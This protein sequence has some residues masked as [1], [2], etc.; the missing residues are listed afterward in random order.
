MKNRNIVAKIHKDKSEKVP[1]G[2]FYFLK[3]IFK[4]ECIILIVFFVIGIVSKLIP[5]KSKFVMKYNIE[6]YF[7]DDVQNENY[8]YTDVI[9]AIESNPHISSEDKNFISN[10]L[11]KEIEENI[12]YIDLETLIKKLETLKISY[13][14]KY[15]YNKK[16]GKYEL[17]NPKINSMNIMGN[18]NIA[19]NRIDLYEELDE[20]NI[21]KNYEKEVFDVVKANKGVYFH[22][23][24]HVMTKKSLSTKMNSLSQ[25]VNTQKIDGRSKFSINFADSIRIIHKNTFSEMINELFTRE[26]FD[27]YLQ[28]NNEG[29]IYKSYEEYMIY[30]YALAEILPEETLREYKFNDNESI[31]ISGLLDIDNNIEEVYKLISSINTI[32]LSDDKISDKNEQYYKNIH[33][34]YAYFYEKKYNKNMK[35][36]IEMLLYFYGTPMQT[37]EE[38]KIVRDFLKMDN[39][40]EILNIEPKGYFSK[41]YKNKHK[42]IKVKYLQNGKEMFLEISNKGKELKNI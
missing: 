8:S 28:L 21:S 5:E 24:N 16:T 6:K 17:L 18:Y 22:E 33:D 40:D 30:A 31:L 25:N 12:N 10:S 15:D 23:L 2:P 14:K 42:H 11:K 41:D 26:Y 20:K 3:W 13:Y 38:R 19:I 35:E 36:D 9:K 7:Y 4:V 37:E 1:N 32:I 39:Y 29:K 34:G 27:E